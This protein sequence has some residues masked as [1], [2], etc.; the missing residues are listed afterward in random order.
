[1]VGVCVG[2]P[3]NQTR[4]GDVVRVMDVGRTGKGLVF[5]TPVPVRPNPYIKTGKAK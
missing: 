2:W 3:G 4:S 1:M 5:H